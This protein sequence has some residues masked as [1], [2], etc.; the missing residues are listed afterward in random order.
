[1]SRGLRLL[2]DR[3][4][5][6]LAVCKSSAVRNGPPSFPPRTSSAR[7]MCQLSRH[8]CYWASHSASRMS[9]CMSHAFLLTLPCSPVLAYIQHRLF[10]GPFAYHLRR[11]QEDRPL[12]LFEEAPDSA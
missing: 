3:N 2:M 5:A 6:H 7:H 10:P 11:K 1:M 8:K 9:D 4:V 12:S